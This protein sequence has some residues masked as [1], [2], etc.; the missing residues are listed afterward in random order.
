M[1]ISDGEAIRYILQ[2]E[3]RYVCYLGAGASVEAGVMTAQGICEEIRKE[4]LEHS[5]LRDSDLDWDDPSQRYV[6]CIRK[7]Y[8]TPAKRVQYFR[9]ML[10]N[11]RPS[12]CHHA[13]AL[14][15]RGNYFK[16]NCQII[17]NI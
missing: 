15:M 8:P 6:T 14:L 2:E 12:F 11:I 10:K 16:I 13:V 4:L 17:G 7:G 5:S 9:R 1:F 3:N